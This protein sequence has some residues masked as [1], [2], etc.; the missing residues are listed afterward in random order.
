MRPE[1]SVFAQL[2][3]AIEAL[4][5]L[6]AEQTPPP[7]DDWTTWLFLGGRGAG[8][9][10]AGAQWV[11]EQAEFGIA[12]NIALVGPTM[13]D[14]RDVQIL[15]NSG[16][17]EIS[18]NSFRPTWEPSKR[19]LVYPNG[20]IAQCFCSEEPE[21]LRGPQFHCAWLDELCAWRNA[22]ETFNML[23]FG[24]RL[25]KQPRQVITTTPK[26]QKLLKKLLASKDVVVTRGTTYSNRE[27]L[28]ESFFSQV[29][30]Q[31]EGSRLGRQELL[32][33]VLEDLEGALWSSEVIE[34]SR[35][36]RDAL[37]PLKRIVVSIDPATT[38]SED[39]DETGI[40]VGGLGIDGHGYI[41]ED[42]SGKY[43]PI[44][45]ARRAIDLYR[46][47]NADRIVAEVNN[48]GLMVEQTIRSVD[49]NVSFKSV[50]ASRGKLVRAEPISA[51][52]EQ[53]RAHMVGMFPQLE[54]QLTSF[55]GGSGSSPDRLDAM[56]WGMTELMLSPG[57]GA[58]GWLDYYSTQASE[59]QSA[60][61]AAP[62]RRRSLFD[63]A[64]DQGASVKEL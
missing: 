36:S 15:G 26:P 55:A 23:Q 31:Y 62:P 9:T 21:R 8:K 30:R 34:A 47:W 10:F 28:A 57:N 20:C 50:N 32:A 61:A 45:W 58:Q 24:L 35:I 33:T 64:R 63:V 19:R 37:V 53:R 14:V 13:A 43:S 27:H 41:L 4:P 25:G 48:G 46:R 52:W 54:D 7:G 6:R 12:K 42:C 59:A 16:L 18:P 56:V 49:E 1:T 17:I 38:V 2:A 51:L 22:E 11:R 40:I 5:T 60:A 39:S 29:I 3:S 44:E